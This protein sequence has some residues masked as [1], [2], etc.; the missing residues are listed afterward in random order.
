MISNIV[1]DFLA[2]LYL[3]TCPNK[4]IVYFNATNLIT[5]P[6]E[7]EKKILSLVGTGKVVLAPIIFHVHWF[8]VL[9]EKGRLLIYDSIIRDR[10]F[11]E[12]INMIQAFELH[13]GIGKF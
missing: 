11:Y 9:V 6:G 1:V 4:D 2:N 3:K 7:S 10:C 12:K 5:T 8:L 13:P